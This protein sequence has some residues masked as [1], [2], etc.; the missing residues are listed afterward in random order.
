MKI[1][2]ATRNAHKLEEIRA[3]FKGEGL[4]ICSAFDFPT[5]PDVV[6]DGETL[7]E[8]AIKK[9]VEM[10]MATGFWTIG[11]DS[12]LEVNAL[13]GA[14]GVYSARYAG[15][16]CS[17]EKNNEKLLLELAGVADRSAQFRTVL[18][19]SNP[20]G[21]VWTVE[22][23]CAGRIIESLRGEGGFGYDPLFIPSES[24]CTFAEMSADEKNCISHRA[25][26]LEKAKKEWSS[27]LKTSF[28][29]R[30]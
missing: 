5:V 16:M 11:D 15:E 29:R 18:S 8:N 4:E 24:K 28:E 2:I 7:E 27:I 13:G 26:A 19:L 17:Y 20:K 21:E 14:P 3:I 25:K 30:K 23:I 10:A 6:E 22:G 12:G 9:A 1:L